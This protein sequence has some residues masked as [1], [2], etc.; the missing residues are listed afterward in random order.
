MNSKGVAPIVIYIF[1]TLVIL[2][3]VSSP[4]WLP[5]AIKG[6]MNAVT[7]G[8]SNKLDTMLNQEGVPNTGGEYDITGDNCEPIDLREYCRSIGASRESRNWWPWFGIFGDI[9]YKSG[10]EPPEGERKDYD[11]LINGLIDAGLYDKVKSFCDSSAPK[12][13][14]WCNTD[15]FYVKDKITDSEKDN[16]IKICLNGELY[17]TLQPKRNLSGDDGFVMTPVATKYFSGKQIFI[18]DSAPQVDQPSL[19]RAALKILSTE[20]SYA[21]LDSKNNAFSEALFFSYGAYYSGKQRDA[22][23]YLVLPVFI[24]SDK[25]VESIKSNNPRIRDC[26]PNWFDNASVT[27]EDGAKKV[28]DTAGNIVGAAIEGGADGY[29]RARGITPIPANMV[30]YDVYFSPYIPG[31]EKYVN[32]FD[33]KGNRLNIPCYDATKASNM[34]KEAVAWFKNTWSA[35][36]GSGQQVSEPEVWTCKLLVI[37]GGA[38][39][40]TITYDADG[41]SGTKYAADR[42]TVSA[43]GEGKDVWLTSGLPENLYAKVRIEGL[44][45]ERLKKYSGAFSFMYN[46]KLLKK[47]FAGN[48]YFYAGGTEGF[49]KKA[50]SVDLHLDFRKQFDSLRSNADKALWD[51]AMFYAYVSVKFPDHAARYERLLFLKQKQKD[52]LAKQLKNPPPYNSA[53]NILWYLCDSQKGGGLKIGK[54]FSDGLTELAKSAEKLDGK[55]TSLTY[56]DWDAFAADCGSNILVGQYAENTIPDIALNKKHWN[57]SF[58][59]ILEDKDFEYRKGDAS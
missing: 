48:G 51:D 12:L 4:L 36:L 56:A 41:D 38:A 43:S 26:N 50:T 3:L 31:S 39:S 27:I 28:F 16:V 57:V 7:M 2:A 8:A 30:Q 49:D 45:D 37:K 53:L 44:S 23:Y 21:S 24:F 18:E 1:W 52:E 55:D 59:K 22:K 29:N 9:E 46:G 47:D 32:V 34:T 20:G 58:N 33:D 15:A 42:E 5:A 40:Y 35:Y 19:L 11:K 13:Y 54:S 14:Y 25:L 6:V 17:F 10:F